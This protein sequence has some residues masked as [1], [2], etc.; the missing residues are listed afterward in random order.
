MLENIFQRAIVLQPLLCVE[1]SDFNQITENIKAI[2]QELTAIEDMMQ[3]ES[4]RCTRGRPTICITEP[5]LQN[6]LELHFSQVEI[7][8]LFGCSAQTVKRRILE[9]GL[10][11]TIEYS[12]TIRIW[13]R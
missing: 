5:Q 3:R 1:V 8:A 2:L 7:T 6:L 13:M 12:T 4:Q 9:Y 10:Q 11:E